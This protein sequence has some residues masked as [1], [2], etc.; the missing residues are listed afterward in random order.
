VVG[1]GSYGG[2]GDGFARYTSLFRGFK[3]KKKFSEIQD[4]PT[5]YNFLHTFG[6][7]CVKRLVLGKPYL[8]F[9]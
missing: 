9:F 1:D 5:E 3:K 7:V 8:T 6:G 2:S 4:K